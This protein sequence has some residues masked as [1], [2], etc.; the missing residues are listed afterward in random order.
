MGGISHEVQSE[1]STLS[2]TSYGSEQLMIDRLWYQWDSEAL[3]FFFP[4]LLRFINPVSVSLHAGTQDQ[5]ATPVKCY[6]SLFCIL[7]CEIA[8]I[9]D[10]FLSDNFLKKGKNNDRSQK[11]TRKNKLVQLLIFR[12]FQR[13]QGLFAASNVAT[14]Y[15]IFMTSPL[16]CKQQL[17]TSDPSQ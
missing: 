4:S 1:L 17:S 7:Q 16:L 3:F 9:E 13:N 10:V 8:Q 12:Q 15:D 5:G 2:E 11:V 6:K 14:Y